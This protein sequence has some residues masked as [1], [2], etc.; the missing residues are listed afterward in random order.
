MGPEIERRLLVDFDFLYDFYTHLEEAKEGREG[1]GGGGML[2]PEGL[3]KRVMG[4]VIRVEQLK[5]EVQQL[6]V[7]SFFFFFFFLFLLFSFPFSL[8]YFLFFFW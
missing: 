6:Q 3:A 8:S 1:G 4:E 7:Y 2:S 5:K